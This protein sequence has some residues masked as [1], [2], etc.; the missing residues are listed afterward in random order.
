M[1]DRVLAVLSSSSDQRSELAT[2][3]KTL[4]D[5]LQTIGELNGR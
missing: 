3:R 1:C 5:Q 4:A 2:L